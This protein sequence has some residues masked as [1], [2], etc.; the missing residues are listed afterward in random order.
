MAT[1]GEAD[2]DRAAELR[3]RATAAK[4]STAKRTL[5]DAA[6]RLESR[7]ARKMAKLARRPR[8]SGRSVRVVS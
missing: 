2:L 6:D 4:G 3:K 5:L 7:G 8:R 1:R